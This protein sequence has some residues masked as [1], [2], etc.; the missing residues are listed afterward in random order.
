MTHL[1]SPNTCI[2][3]YKIFSSSA[4]LKEFIKP[5]KIYTYKDG[6]KLS[7]YH[8]AWC[9]FPKI[10]DC[11]NNHYLFGYYNRLSS[12][13]I[14]LEVKSEDIEI[15]DQHENLELYTAH[16]ISIIREISFEEFGQLSTG[17]YESWYNTI[18][19]GVKQKEYEN[20][21]KNGYE[22]ST[23]THWYK[24][25]QKDYEV[26]YTNEGMDN[27]HVSW[28]KNFKP[29]GQ[30]KKAELHSKNGKHLEWYLNGQ[31]SVEKN[32]KN[33]LY[34]G[35]IASWDEDGKIIYDD[36]YKLD[37]KVLDFHPPE[38]HEKI[39]TYSNKTVKSIK[40][41]Q[42]FKNTRQE[43]HFF[44]TV[45]CMKINLKHCD[46]FGQKQYESSFKNNVFNG[47]QYAWYID[48]QPFYEKNYINGKEDGQQLCWYE[49]VNKKRYNYFY[50]NGV[51]DGKQEYWYDKGETYNVVYYKNGE[52]DNEMKE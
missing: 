44:P 35:R 2:T 50:V 48:G 36:V 47:K 3:G 25:G 12:D 7:P 34:D 14:F 49:H 39:E 16:N 37:N 31:I 13:N 41:Y 28:Y 17:I 43:I 27:T 9:F 19:N 6:I 42:N 18:L 32:Y 29:D 38:Y 52:I 51:M 4:D 24:N 33:G 15:S 21:Y 11:I 46:K 5:G 1:I 45:N 23:H 20:N 40:K 26:T 22:D 8:E 10:I 30:Q